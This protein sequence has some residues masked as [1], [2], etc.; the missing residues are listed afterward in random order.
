MHSISACSNWRTCLYNDIITNVEELCSVQI[1]S[2]N[3]SDLPITTIWL[4]LYKMFFNLIQQ[5]IH[6]NIPPINFLTYL[7]QPSDC[8]STRDFST[9]FSNVCS[10]ITFLTFM[11]PALLAVDLIGWIQE[12]FNLMPQCMQ[13]SHSHF[14]SPSITSRSNCM[15]TRVFAAGSGY[16]NIPKKLF[17]PPAQLG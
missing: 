3:F 7:L 8:I 16:A 13:I 11:L 15:Y 5:C 2:N 10:R 12:F 4:H 9:F 6:A 1:Y 14:A 17:Q